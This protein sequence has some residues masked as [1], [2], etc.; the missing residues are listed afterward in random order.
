MKK[1]TKIILTLLIIILLATLGVIG[2]LVYQKLNPSTQVASNDDG[3]NGTVKVKEQPINTWKGN[4]R[5]IMVSIDNQED[6]RPQAGLNDAAIVYEFIAE[7]GITRL[8][9]VF[10]GADIDKIGPVRSAR[11][12]FLDYAMENDAIFVHYGW[13]PQAQSDIP[14]LGINNING[15]TEDTGTSSSSSFWR[16]KDKYAPHNA[17]T[18]TKNLLKI[19]KEDDYR[20][21]STEDSPLNFVGH[22]VNLNETYKEE[23]IPATEVDIRFS[24]YCK[25]KYTYDKVRQRY[26]K[27]TDGDENTDW[28]SGEPITAKNVLVVSV[29]YSLLNDSENKGRQDIDNIG[30]L[31][32]YYFTNGY[33]IK[34]KAT[35]ESRSGKTTYTD[36]NG[37]VIEINDGNT[38]I[39]MIDA[40]ESKLEITPGESAKT[41]TTTNTVNEE[42]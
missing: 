16:V 7:G 40:D 13:S 18:N 19:A 41:A 26:T 28:D 42:E 38:H 3:G 32:G 23:A 17:V 36:M 10:K 27:S 35:K 11:H 5:P 15:L 24:S 34:I 2:F 9:E 12:Y 30:T 20:L 29:E 22:V 8:L 1:S 21:T 31:S 4:D 14:K 6:A 33:A 25:V 37:K 39:E